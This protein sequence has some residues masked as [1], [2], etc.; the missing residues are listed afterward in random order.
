M[1]KIPFNNGWQ[2]LPDFKPSYLKQP[3]PN[4]SQVR[5]PHTNIEL[6][7]HY[8]DEKMYQFVSSYQKTW[9][10]QVDQTKRY[11]LHFE[12]VMAV[13]TVY[14]NNQE[15]FTHLGGYT[16]FKVD[17]TDVINDGENTVFVKVDSN[18]V[19]NVPPFGFVVD[20]L[21]YG[22]I[23]REVQLIEVDA[24]RIEDVFI[25]TTSDELV[26][27][28][29]REANPTDALKCT[30]NVK[31]GQS[32]IDSFD[33]I[34]ETEHTHLVKPMI[35]KTWDIDDPHLYTLEVVQG[36]ILLY[37]STF[38]KRTIEFKTDGFYLNGQRI[39]LRGLNRH[40]SYP[41]VG[42]AMPKRPQQKDADLLK[43]DL[44]CNV[45]RSS[46]YPPS[47]H[48]LDRCDEIGLLVVTELPGWQH[49]G[50]EEWKNVAKQNV[51]DMILRDRNHPS[52]IMWGVR[53]N[54][55]P[56][57]DAFYQATNAIAR[58]LDPTRPT[59]GV[60]NF[61]NSHFFED[62]Y[63]YNDFVHRGNNEGLEKPKKVTK[64]AVPYLVTEYNGHMYPTKPF[65]DEIHRI[66]QVKRHLNVQNQSYADEHISGAIGWCMFDYNTHKDFGSGDKICYHGV[67]DMFRHKKYAAHVYASQQSQAPYL[68]VASNLQ[69]GDFEA[70]EIKEVIVL[71]NC[72]EVKFYINDDYINTFTP[73]SEYSALPHPPIIIDDFIGRL[74][75]DNEPFS[76]KDASTIKHILLHIM[77]H[78]MNLPLSLKLKMG[79][80]L[81]KNKL[82]IDQAAKLY[83]KYVGKWGLESLTYRFEGYK[84]GQCVIQKDVGPTAQTSI[85]VVVEDTVLN[86]TE[87]YDVTKVSVKHLDGHD[88]VCS[89]S[90][91]I[92]TLSI[93]GPLECIGPVSR[94]LRGGTTAFYVKTVGELGDA[95]LKISTERYKTV[96]KKITIK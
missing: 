48:F 70:S 45:V 53:I 46:H 49:I 58:E 88:R 81:F 44:G 40:Q 75:H 24:Q 35:L 21:T 34:L 74:I 71:T 28:I 92:I 67:M 9:T 20:Y 13:A 50:D 36:D 23:Y 73:S 63:T 32:L 51:R 89:Y 82:S 18:E 7:Y 90:D 66:N 78:G 93:E 42:Y 10:Q 96:T 95:T 62:V 16:P 87:T 55:S 59:G 64:Q 31:K 79:L 72:D 3:L 30:F 52:I 54:E 12:A 5:L 38:A 26:L 61:K 85:D 19:D 84:A 8:F 2:Y 29:K 14:V 91:E 69:I 4:A 86:E 43:Y 94:V 6:P 47:R 76:K 15:L 37:E 17:I 27:N 22:G 57:D 33:D 11:F 68:E 39:K 65:D 77:K 1:K 56:D 83:E 41:Y 25:T 60:R 80:V